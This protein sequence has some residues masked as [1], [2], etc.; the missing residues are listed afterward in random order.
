[1]KKQNST[2]A[3]LIMILVGAVFLLISLSPNL[4]ERL[5]ISR[6]WP[7]LIILVGLFFLITALFG[8]SSLSIPGSVI[9]GIGSI[10]YYQNTTGNWASWVYIWTLIPGFVGIGLVLM[11]LLD[12]QRRKVMRAGSR[13]LLISA[14][15]FIVFGASF[16][17]LGKLGEF[18]PV[19]LIG[20]GM[21]MLFRNRLSR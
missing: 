1:M 9:T 2:V 21:W 4:A 20:S 15:L 10:L 18:W 7:L 8:A 5:D 16:S 17:G 14:A 13:L 11:G 12:K 19:L 6:Q 3:G